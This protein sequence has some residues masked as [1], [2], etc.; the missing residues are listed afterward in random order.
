MFVSFIG[1]HAREKLQASRSIREK[2]VAAQM[3]KAA[4]D[5]EVKKRSESG[6]LL[7]AW[8]GIEVPVTPRALRAPL[9][10]GASAWQEARARETTPQRAL[11]KMKRKIADKLRKVAIIRRGGGPPRNTVCVFPRVILTFLPHYHI[12]YK[13]IDSI[14]I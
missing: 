1:E 4:G 3:P 13:S 8:N 9:S 14:R 10:E 7:Y 12:S 5:L 2:G 6:Q 11:R